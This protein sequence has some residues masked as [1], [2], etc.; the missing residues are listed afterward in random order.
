MLS[1]NSSID[2]SILAGGFLSIEPCFRN[3]KVTFITLLLS[4]IQTK[5]YSAY[6]PALNRL[7]NYRSIVEEMNFE[8]EGRATS[9]SDK[10]L[11]LH[12]P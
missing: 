4:C 2:V 5:K 10:F 3:N 6:F 8:R 1:W 9:L 11:Y 7:P 12:A